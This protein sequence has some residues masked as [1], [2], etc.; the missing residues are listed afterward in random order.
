[1]ARK[2]SLGITDDDISIL[3]AHKHTMNDEDIDDREGLENEAPVIRDASELPA[4]LSKPQPEKTGAALAALIKTMD[5]PEV[6][7]VLAREE[8]YYTYL[9]ASESEKE[10]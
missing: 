2:R 1:M 3:T 10:Q 6:Q 9:W 7:E 4:V 5:T 8:T